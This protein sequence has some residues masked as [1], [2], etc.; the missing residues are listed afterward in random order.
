MLARLREGHALFTAGRHVDARRLFE[1]VLR[2]DPRQHDALN[3]LGLIAA[4]QG[5]IERAVQLLRRAVAAMP[6]FGNGWCNLGLMLARLGRHEEALEAY[7]RGSA[8]A[9]TPGADL[10]SA[11]QHNRGLSLQKLGR[12]TEALA[13]FDAVLQHQPRDGAA[14]SDRGLALRELNRPEEAIA[15]YQRAL[16]LRPDYGAMHFAIAQC[17]LLLG[18]FAAGLPGLEWRHTLV[19]GGGGPLRLP[20]GWRGPED[21]AGRSVLLTA[22]QG[23]GDTLQFCRYAPMVASLAKRVTLQVQPSLVRLVASIAG[24]CEVI[25]AGE[26]PPE[27]DIAIPLMSLPLA[28]GTDLDSVPAR[29]PYLSAPSDVRDA[30]AARL[31]ARTRPQI[32]IAWSGRE[33]FG[34]DHARSLRLATLLPALPEGPEYWVV[35]TEIRAADAELLERTPS[36]QQRRALLSDFAETAGL[37]AQLDLVVTTDTAVAHL[38]GALGRPVWLLLAHVP[39]WRWLRAREDSPWYPTM[40]LLR[41]DALGDWHPARRDLGCSQQK[42]RV[43]WPAD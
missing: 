21:L 25:A 34:N 6:G 42:E 30:W 31:G 4:E 28:F 32:G 23:F 22:E 43:P 41:Q 40:R 38:A 24:D 29:I 2:S 15:S 35:Q 10:L 11:L 9:G 20:Q 33:T 12:R 27:A 18:D 26:A 17:H 1:R 37:M 8:V 13:C 39:E 14:W 36:L 19:A 3:L 5:E 16:D 7:A